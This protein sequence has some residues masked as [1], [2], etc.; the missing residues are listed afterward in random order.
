MMVVQTQHGEPAM[1]EIEHDRSRARARTFARAQRGIPSREV[2]A[3]NATG[4]GL[5]VLDAVVDE[6]DLAAA[7]DFSRRTASRMPWS[8]HSPTK[9]RTE[10]R[11]GG[12]GGNN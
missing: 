1:I 8:D 5:D 2:A 12:R 3:R 10:S 9:V 4:D 7:P 11:F 6:I